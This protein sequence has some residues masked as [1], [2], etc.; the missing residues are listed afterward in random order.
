[1]RVAL[2]VYGSPTETDLRFAAQMGCSGVVVHVPGIPGDNGRWEVDDLVRLRKG[3]EAFG[4]RLESVENTPWSF[5][6]DAML[7]GPRAEEQ[8][9]NYC[10]SIRSL[11][12]A[13][14]P[15]LGFCWMPNDVWSTTFDAPGRGGARVRQFDLS[16][17]DQDGLTHGRVYHEDEMWATYTRFIQAVVPAAESAGVRLALHPDDPPVESLGGIARIFRD[18][19]HF[20]RGMEIL[21]SPNLGLNFCMGS[22]SE[23][24]PGVIDSLRYFGELKKVFY[25]H[26]RDVKG[27]VPR[28]EECFLGEGNVNVVEAVRTLKSFG[29]DGCMENDHVP[30]MLDETPWAP[31]SRSH[32][33]GYMMGLVNA[34]GQLG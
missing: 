17:A 19:D 9:D 14:I 33:T 32:A 29:F 28:F 5:Y 27:H 1:M 31:L 10:Y 7:G 4:L 25:V 34:V 26:F 22:W 21:P 13:E 16:Q 20:K 18:F 11:G 12:D 2:G 24:G 6:L 23:M 30:I 3:I 8:I 15:I